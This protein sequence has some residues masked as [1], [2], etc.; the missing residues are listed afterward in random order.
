[1]RHPLYFPMLLVTMLLALVA[2]NHLIPYL[3]TRYGFNEFATIAVLSFGMGFVWLGA[4]RT[5]RQ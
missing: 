4:I 2:G 5:L 3:V 1:M